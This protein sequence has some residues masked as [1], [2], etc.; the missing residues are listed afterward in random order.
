MIHS[1]YGKRRFP[2]GADFERL[3]RGDKLRFEALSGNALY[4]PDADLKI[5]VSYDRQARTLTVSD[6]G[7]GMSR[8]ESSTISAPSPSPGRASSSSRSRAD[9]AKDAR[10]I[11]AVR[12]GLLFVFYRRGTASRS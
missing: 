1:L 5:R 10:M 11:G 12:G 8:E 6:N 3:R 9:Q 2:E 7:I 4:G